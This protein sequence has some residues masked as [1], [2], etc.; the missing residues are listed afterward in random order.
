MWYS[1]VAKDGKTK[2]PP[3]LRA[4]L[5]I[6][7]GD[8]LHYELLD[9]KMVVSVHAGTASLKGALAS[10]KGTGLS[11]DRIRKGHASPGYHK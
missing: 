3:E 2:L 8:R 10:T 1:T 7:P 9:E 5:G 4:A 6:K 11:F